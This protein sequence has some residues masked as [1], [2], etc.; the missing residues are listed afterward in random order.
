MCNHETGAFFPE[1]LS[2]KPRQTVRNLYILVCNESMWEEA[3]SQMP[4][5]TGL[6]GN[7]RGQRQVIYMSDSEEEE[8]PMLG[9]QPRRGD[10]I[11]H[12]GMGCHNR[13]NFRGL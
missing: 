2:D 10:L 7:G 6:D 9:G 13:P 5:K 3:R 1:G 12:D 11:A 4:T 8:V